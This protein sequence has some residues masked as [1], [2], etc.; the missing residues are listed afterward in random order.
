MG[1]SS[2]SPSVDHRF[3]RGPPQRLLRGGVAE[4]SAE[5]RLVRLGQAEL[6]LAHEGAHQCVAVRVKPRRGQADDRV[7]RPDGRT[8]DHPRSLHDPDGGPGQVEGAGGHQPRVLGRL[9]ADERAARRPATRRDAA[10]QLGHRHGIELADGHVVEER[11]RLGAAAG[12]VVDAH[13]HEVDPDR[14]EASD[15][16]GDRGL[17]PD[18]VGRGHEHRLA[19]T[20]RYA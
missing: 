19:I 8:V 4:R 18:A 15:P 1:V 20:G 16:G 10:H 12:D 6:P 2:V 11:E 5:A 9:A 13:R 17:G 7:A 3:V 14:V